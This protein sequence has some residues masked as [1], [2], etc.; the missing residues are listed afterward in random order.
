VDQYPRKAGLHHHGDA[1]GNVIVLT[2][3]NPAGGSNLTTNYTYTSANQLATVS[4][5]RARPA[6]A[7]EAEATKGKPTHDPRAPGIR[8]GYVPHA[9]CA[10]LGYLRMFSGPVERRNPRCVR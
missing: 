5:P 2:E 3:P 8:I 6:F 9:L 10:W 7:A 1:F 4:M